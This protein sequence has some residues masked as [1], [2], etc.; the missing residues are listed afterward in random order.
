MGDMKFKKTYIDQEVCSGTRYMPLGRH[1][2]LYRHVQLY[3]EGFLSREGLN[4]VG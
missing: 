2:D 3:S 1:L 4:D